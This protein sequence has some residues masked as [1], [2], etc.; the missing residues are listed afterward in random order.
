MKN[1]LE[2]EEKQSL[3]YKNEI[4]DLKSIVNEHKSEQFNQ[5]QHLQTYAL[6]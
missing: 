1:K 5:L 6:S 4:C 3:L 2:A